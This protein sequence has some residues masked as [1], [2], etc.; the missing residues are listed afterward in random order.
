MLISRV[1]KVSGLLIYTASGQNI[2]RSLPRLGSSLAA[3]FCSRG[4]CTSAVKELILF[5][6]PLNV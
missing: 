2:P 4:G 5:M 1:L 3:V 6:K